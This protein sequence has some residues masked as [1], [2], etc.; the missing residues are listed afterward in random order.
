MTGSPIGDALQRELRDAGHDAADAMRRLTHPHQFRHD[1][2]DAPA[3]PAPAQAVPATPTEAP[4]MSLLAAYDKAKAI[5]TELAEV[6][7]DV[8]EHVEAILANPELKLLI[9]VL[10]TL[11]K[12]ALPE[13]FITDAGAVFQLLTKVAALAPQPQADPVA[14]AIA[15]DAQAQTGA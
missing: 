8:V 2:H 9:P 3:A 4:T 14:A 7:R 6:D 15:A 12:A 13:G 1:Q 11:A 5:G 10:G